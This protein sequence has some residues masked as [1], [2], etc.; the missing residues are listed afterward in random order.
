MLFHTLAPQETVRMQLEFL[1]VLS[2][3]I[4]ATAAVTLRNWK[5]PSPQ[6]LPVPLTRPWHHNFLR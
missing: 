6:S 1:S 4:S 2:V 3:G 5:K